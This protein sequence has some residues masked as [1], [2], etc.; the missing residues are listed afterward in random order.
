MDHHAMPREW[1]DRDFDYLHGVT[2]AAMLIGLVPNLAA[3]QSGGPT[4]MT[5]VLD[6]LAGVI[7]TALE[8]FL[9]ILFTPIETVIERH[10]DTLLNV[11]VSTPHPDAIV[12]TPSNGAWPA[13]HAYYWE[14]LIPISLGLYAVAIGLIVLLET[15]SHLFS[16]YHRTKLKRRAFAGLVGLLTWWWFAGFSL[17]MVDQLTT[18]LTPSLTDVTLFETLSF[19]AMGVLGLVIS[20][21]V[22]F[23]FF[24]LIGLVYLARHLVLYMFVLLMPLL[25]VLW[26]PGV[27]PFG[28]AAG[29]ARNLAGF[30]VPFLVM[31]I[32]V[33]LLLRL[34]EL[35]GQSAAF[36]MPGIGSWIAAM[37]LPF[38]ALIAPVVLITQAGQVQSIAAGISRELSGTRAARRASIVK[39]RVDESTTQRDTFNARIGSNRPSIREPSGDNFAHSTSRTLTEPSSLRPMDYASTS[40]WRDRT[41]PVAPT[42][43]NDSSGS[44]E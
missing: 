34:S 35:L 13:L 11:L 2:N 31:P 16:S 41:Y 23:V 8:E 40:D 12:G 44:A 15:T 21:L 14:Q 9:R 4:P 39:Q 26:V 10:V 43:Q 18:I 7:V 5:G 24:V 1:S 25:I 22:D 19:S 17:A 28:Q 6:G 36:T 33:A 38:A 20:L 42:A 30:Y 32:P 29:F 37:V 3:A 27:G